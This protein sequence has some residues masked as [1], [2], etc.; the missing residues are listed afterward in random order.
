MASPLDRKSPPQPGSVE[1]GK[2]KR[3]QDGF[4]A[5]YEEI[6]QNCPPS[7]D[8]TLAVRKLQEASMWATHSVMFEGEPEE[9][10]A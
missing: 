2:L 6:V 10:K 8:R 7:A 3:L 5:A 4:R 9:F 1:D